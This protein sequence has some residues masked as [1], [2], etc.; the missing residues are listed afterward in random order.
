[1]I[2][3]YLYAVGYLNVCFNNENPYI[4]TIGLKV[5]FVYEQNK[6]YLTNF[7]SILYFYLTFSFIRINT[8]NILFFIREISINVHFLQNDK[9]VFYRKFYIRPS[10]EYNN[11]TVNS[12]K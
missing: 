10:A 12:S 8:Y 9:N 5:V 1:M 2:S 3:Y 4:R 6:Q 11:R 7:S